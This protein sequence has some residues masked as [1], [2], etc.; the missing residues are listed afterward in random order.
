VSDLVFYV[1]W[2]LLSIALVAVG[3]VLFTAVLG[4]LGI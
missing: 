1:K 2:M 4:A 3:V